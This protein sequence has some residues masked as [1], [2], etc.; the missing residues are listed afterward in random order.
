MNAV[1][2]LAGTLLEVTAA[3]GTTFTSHSDKL[4][5]DIIPGFECV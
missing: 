1:S 5:N 2:G 4:T 3:S